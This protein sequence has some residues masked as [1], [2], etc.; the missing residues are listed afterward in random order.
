MTFHW[1]SGCP[2]GAADRPELAEELSVVLLGQQDAGAS[3]A[4]ALQCC[5]C[6]LEVANMKD[7]K[8]QLDV[9]CISIHSTAQELHVQYH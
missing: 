4:D 5:D 7:R 6:A 1:T 2:E 9:A 3:L 8:P